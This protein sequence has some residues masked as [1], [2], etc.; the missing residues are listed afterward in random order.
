MSLF[1]KSI[2]RDEPSGEDFLGTAME[3]SQGRGS[4]LA[5]EQQ[6]RDWNL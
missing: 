4:L 6:V 2:K 5:L 1:T 3:C